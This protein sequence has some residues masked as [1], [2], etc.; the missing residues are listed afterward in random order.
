MKTANESEAWEVRDEFRNLAPIRYWVVSES[1]SGNTSR[2]GPFH[3][4]D[5]AQRYADQLNSKE[6]V[7]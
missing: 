6:A 3:S 7:R 2:V 4:R 5:E 1:K